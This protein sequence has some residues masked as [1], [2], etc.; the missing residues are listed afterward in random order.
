M[1][2]AIRVSGALV[3]VD[4]RVLTQNLGPVEAGVTEYPPLITA[5]VHQCASFLQPK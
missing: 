5:Y 3:Q 2:N 1:Y 4:S